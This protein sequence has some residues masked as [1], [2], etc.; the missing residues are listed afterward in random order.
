MQTELS[1]FDKENEDEE[2]DPKHKLRS[3]PSNTT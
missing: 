3:I 2:N 1:F